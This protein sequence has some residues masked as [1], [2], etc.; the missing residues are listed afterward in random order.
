MK[1]VPV[2]E[3]IISS[4]GSSVKSDISLPS[5]HTLA[6]R[7]K[8]VQILQKRLC[9]LSSESNRMILLFEGL[10]TL[11]PNQVTYLINRYISV[12]ESLFRRTLFF[13]YQFH[14][15]RTVITVGS[16]FV[17][18]LLSIQYI[19]TGGAGDTPKESGPSAFFWITWFLSLLVTICNGILTLFKVDKK[20]YFLHTTHEQLKSQAWQYLY[21]TGKYGGHYT[22]GIVPT[23]ANQYIF[24]CHNI[25]KIKLKQVEEEYYKLV[26]T[27]SEDSA[28]HAAHH[29]N[30]TEQTNGQIHSDKSSRNIA[31]L[32]LPTP[33]QNE[34]ISH[35]QELAN[36]LIQNGVKL[37]KNDSPVKKINIPLPNSDSP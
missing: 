11:T 18:A 37:E 19:N 20:Y 15:G 10:E 35:K 27:Q 7:E 33:E 31:G 16:L 8:T 3:V 25:E 34:L 13:A 5:A 30:G 9:G 21:L 26:D 36:A 2:P 22:K 12:T 32:Y 29:P 6:I 23:H 17:S 24:F 1:V 4:V 28:K 14:I